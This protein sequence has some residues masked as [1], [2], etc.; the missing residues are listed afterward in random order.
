MHLHLLSWL[1]SNEEYAKSLQTDHKCE[2]VVAAGLRWSTNNMA[3]VGNLDKTA[4]VIRCL[5]LD[6]DVIGVRKS[7]SIYGQP[8][9][10]LL[11]DAQ[12]GIS[13][14]SCYAIVSSLDGWEH[15][16]WMPIPV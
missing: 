15:G 7:E 4:I 6:G 16:V 11:H 3:D 2:L 9:V 5:E 8:Q 10:K 13:S 12:F 14:E 1:M